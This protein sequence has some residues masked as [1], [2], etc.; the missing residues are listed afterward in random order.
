M[1]QV[2]P[3][4]TIIDA[5]QMRPIVP[6]DVTCQ[7]NSQEFS[8][9]VP[10]ARSSE[11]QPSEMGV[12]AKSPHNIEPS[13]FSRDETQSVDNTID[14]KCG[15][16]GPSRVELSHRN[17]HVMVTRNPPSDPIYSYTYDQSYG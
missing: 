13:C 7:E 14:V 8:I 4:V 9:D 17:S 2:S 15:I 5:G 6:A 12:S 16:V 11:A 3:L 1:P 10:G